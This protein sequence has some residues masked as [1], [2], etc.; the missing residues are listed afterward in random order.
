MSAT[1]GPRAQS[2]S[3]SVPEERL[4]PEELCHQYANRVYRFATMVAGGDVEAEDLAQEA[5]MRA[6]RKLGRF[7]PQRGSIETWLWRIVVNAARDCGRVAGRRRALW[8]RLIE[9]REEAPGTESL[10]LDNLTDAELLRA[11]RRLPARDRAV[12]GLRF[13]ADLDYIAVGREL[14]LTAAAATM[15]LHRALV[16]LR[17]ELE[18][19]P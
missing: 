10:A 12:I 3:Q 5:L 9:D 19:R 7:D 14:G 6:I 2:W 8:L 13:G 4:T 16:R 18:E 17:K 11:V 15:A 1:G